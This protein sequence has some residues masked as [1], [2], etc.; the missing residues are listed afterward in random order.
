MDVYRNNYGA[1]DLCDDECQ[2]QVDDLYNNFTECTDPL[3]YCPDAPSLASSLD[4][5]EFLYAYRHE[6]GVT[7]TGSCQVCAPP[8]HAPHCCMRARGD[9]PNRTLN[10]EP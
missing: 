2:V 1:S 8:A 3:D 9:N 10:P 5:C 7:C 6:I 4:D